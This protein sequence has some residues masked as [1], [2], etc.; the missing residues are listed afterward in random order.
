M[1]SLFVSMALFTGGLAVVLP[2]FAHDD[3]STEGG[4]TLAVYGD[5][6]YGCKAPSSAAAPDECPVGSP[7]KPDSPDGPNP[8]DPRQIEATP[9][10]IDAVNQDPRV[11]LVVHV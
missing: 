10:F 2:A 6:P 9:A 4:F 11:D 3:E 1:K 8:G 5:A 7:W